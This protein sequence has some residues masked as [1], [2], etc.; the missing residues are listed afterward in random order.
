MSVPIAEN[1]ENPPALKE[2][3][4]T[5]QVLPIVGAHF[6]HDIYSAFVPTLLPVLIKQL[7]LTLTQAGSLS[8][9]LQLPA[10]FNPLIGY[11]ADKVNLRYFVILTPAITATLIG[12]MGLSPDY[13]ALAVILFTAGISTAAFHAPAPAMVG[14]VSGK[15]L[16]LGMSLFMAAGELSRT[17]GPLIAVWAVSTWTL[18]GIYR[19][20]IL[21]WAAS[22]VLYLRLRQVP[23]RLENPGNLRD[24]LP[25]LVPLFLPLALINLFNDFLL[26]CLTTFLPTYM[27]MQGANLM[28]AGGALS[29][30]SLAGAIGALSSGTVSDRLGRKKVL[31]IATVLSV[32]LM[33]VFLRVQSWLLV[34]ILLLLG[35]TSLSTTP[36]M[37]AMV[38]EN[39]PNNRAVGNG[40]YMFVAFLVRP[41]T[42]IG[43][44]AMGDRWG[45]QTAFFWGTLVSL[46]SLPAILALPGRIKR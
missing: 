42:V 16:G 23:A 33:L 40:L 13:F 35:F 12:C 11:M 34:P 15:K 46:L 14:R 5:S 4:Q 18:S 45:L 39:L 38:Q 8:A 37:L 30:L 36:V 29:I 41:I 44:G 9:M 31:L 17:A 1:I 20:A 27:Q 24:V 10:L 32:I 28:A 22:A 2:Q 25:I 21:G 43:I 3:F 19:T 7:S 6:I 26:A